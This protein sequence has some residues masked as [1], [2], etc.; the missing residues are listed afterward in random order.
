MF[1]NQNSVG[2]G[3]KF[4]VCWLLYDVVCAG[5]GYVVCR[6]PDRPVAKKN[7]DS[8]GPFVDVVRYW[9]FHL[10]FLARTIIIS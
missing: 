10:H 6:T 1:I 5:N 3:G 2:N 4:L 8:P 7:D 9:N